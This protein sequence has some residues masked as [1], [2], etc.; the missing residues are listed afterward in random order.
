[1]SPEKHLESL[2]EVLDEINSALE[3][4][5]GINAHQRRLAL[6]FSL[7]IC[8]LMELYFHRLG[9]IKSGARLKHDWFRQI[10]I[11]EKLEQQITCPIQS[12]QKVE[13]MITIAVEIEESRDDLAY[14]APVK[15]EE[16][17]MKKI[18]QFMDLKNL[19][20]KTVSA[21]YETK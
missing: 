19:I 15:Q 8:D 9:V 6:M 11:K 3:D 7:G 13:E 10:R 12:L 4:P 2:K 17:L 21:L 18:N 1:M 5:R 16:L 14:G 20:E